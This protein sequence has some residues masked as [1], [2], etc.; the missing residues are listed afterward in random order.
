MLKQARELRTAIESLVLSEEP[1]VSP[2][3]ALDGY[4]AQVNALLTQAKQYMDYHHLFGSIP[5]STRRFQ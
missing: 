5:S 2:L 1:V 3:E 4:E